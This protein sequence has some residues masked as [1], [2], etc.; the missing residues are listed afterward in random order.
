MTTRTNRRLTDEERQ[1][2]AEAYRLAEADKDEIVRRGR[3]ILAEEAALES[4]LRDTLRHLHAERLSSGVSLQ[5][6]A[7]RAGLAEPLVAQL[8]TDPTAHPTLGV[9]SRY[10]RA[11]GRKLVVTLAAADPPEMP[12]AIHS[13]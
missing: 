13:S 2:V 8:E 1:R 3:E 5:E 12:V 6:L 10:A 7:S 11:L 4:T 9:L